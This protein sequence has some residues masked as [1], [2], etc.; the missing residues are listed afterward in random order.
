METV[1]KIIMITIS[2]IAFLIELLCLIVL[3]KWLS[4]INKEIKEGVLS[5]KI[6]KESTFQFL[7]N[8]M[9]RL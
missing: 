2:I 9:L 5:G 8:S 3:L 6:K 4:Q 7:L 1:A